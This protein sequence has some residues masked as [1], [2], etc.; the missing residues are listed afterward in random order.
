MFFF[1]VC[2]RY[3]LCRTRLREVV[4]QD[5]WIITERNLERNCP[6][7][8]K[9]NFAPTGIKREIR[10]F[11]HHLRKFSCSKGIRNYFSFKFSLKS[12]G[13]AFWL[14]KK[15]WPFAWMYKVQQKANTSPTEQGCFLWGIKELRSVNKPRVI[16]H[17]NI[18]CLQLRSQQSWLNHRK[19]T[20]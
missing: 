14:C 5:W 17:L 4:S 6:I 1:Q 18:T 2:L 15:H 11:V 10:T 20:Q 9:A 8:C 19:I 7:W 3:S 16:T 12:V 13:S